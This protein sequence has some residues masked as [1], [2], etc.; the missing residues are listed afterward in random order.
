VTRRRRDAFTLIEVLVVI[1][2]IAILAT[3]VGPSLFRNVGDARSA[4]AR[5]Q[6]ETFGTA[7]DAYRLDNGNYPTT[8]QGL[9]AL[10]QRPT[11]DPPSNWRSP[12][13][14]K[15]VP[16][17]PWGRDYIYV[18]PGRVNPEGYDLLSYGADGKAGGEGENADILSWK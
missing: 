15:A 17:D 12:Y 2:V 11:V 3:F 7:L 5:T 16:K 14:R 18:A 6:I 10:W 9:D 8:A 13:L 4:T 1:I